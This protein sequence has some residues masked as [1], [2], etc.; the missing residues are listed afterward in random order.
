[1]TY[2][3][4]NSQEISFK[5]TNYE[6]INKLEY[7]GGATPFT[8]ITNT[9]KS[10]VE[11][12]AKLICTNFQFTG[13]FGLDFIY[14]T[15]HKSYSIIEINPR[16]TTPYIAISALFQENN[17]N[18]LDCIFKKTRSLKIKGKKTFMKSIE[19]KIVLE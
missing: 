14:D 1:M 12:V 8:K 11:N 19:K 6:N 5:S 9:V 17:S 13:F 15:Q 4:I 7:T 16:I 2:F 10:K 3:T 18:I